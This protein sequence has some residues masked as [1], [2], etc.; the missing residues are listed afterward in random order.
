MMLFSLPV[1]LPLFW[2]M[3]PKRRILTLM[4]PDYRRGIVEVACLGVA[5]GEE[6]EVPRLASGDC[7][8]PAQAVRQ[9]CAFFQGDGGDDGTV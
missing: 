9:T 2:A 1:L 4:S 6:K 5:E 7:V 8:L 3:F